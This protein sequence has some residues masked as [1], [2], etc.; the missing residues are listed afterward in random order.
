LLHL[1]DSAMNCRC[2]AYHNSIPEGDFSIVAAP[3]LETP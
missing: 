3:T 1:S 2:A